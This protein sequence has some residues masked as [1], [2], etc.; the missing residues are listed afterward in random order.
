MRIRGLVSML[1][2]ALLLLEGEGTEADPQRAVRML[3]EAAEEG[4]T[5]AM[6][7][8]GEA[9]RIGRGISQNLTNAEIWLRRSCARHYVPA[10][11]PLA[12][13]LSEQLAPP[14]HNSALQVLR[15]GA[16]LGDARS[17]YA[18]AEHYALG[19]GVMEDAAQAAIWFQRAAAQGQTPPASGQS[20]GS[21]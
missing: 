3:L 14:D 18:L 10:F 20:A 21:Q 6:F 4:F 13:L 16:E 1:A 17:Q 7:H 19:R 5:E 9:H 12:C 15:Q 2:L 11:L 8:L